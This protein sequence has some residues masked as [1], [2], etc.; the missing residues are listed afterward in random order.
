MSDQEGESSQP[1]SHVTVKAPI[2][3]KRAPNMWFRQMESQF[4]LARITKSETKFHHVLSALPEDIAINIDID[5]CSDYEKLKEAVLLS[6]KP[7]QH[8]LI[9]QALRGVELGDKRPTQMVSEIR[10][11]FSQIGLEAEEKIIKSQIIAAVPHS[12]RSALVGHENTSVEEFSKI[13]DSML[14]IASTQSNPFL[15]GTVTGDFNRQRNQRVEQQWTSNRPANFSKFSNKFTKFE[16]RPF[17]EGQK[18]RVCNAHIFYG[19]RARSC[20]PWCNWPNKPRRILRDS[21]RTP[22]NSRPNSPVPEQDNL[23]A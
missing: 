19:E 4:I 17:Y 5:T 2:F 10:R 18:P 16:V 13:A 8:E 11:R 14:S 22:R 20:R 21:E 15:V 1:I 3:Y 23:N 12:I 6:V 7:N 9:D